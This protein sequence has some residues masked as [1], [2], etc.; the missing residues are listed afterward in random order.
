M[1]FEHN[2][3]F[4]QTVAFLGIPFAEKTADANRFK[5][6]TDSQGWKG[7]FNATYKRPPCVQRNTTG[8]KG[9]FV[10]ASN[11]TE[12]CLHLN[13]WVPT[14]CVDG[15]QRH[16]VIFWAYGGTFNTG[17][18]S[19]DF[20]D[21]RFISGFGNLVVVAPNYRVGVF[22]FLNAD[23]PDAPG[24]MALHD[25]IAAHDWVMKHIERF[26]GDRD[27][28]IL[29][30]QTPC[31]QHV[32]GAFRRSLTARARSKLTRRRSVIEGKTFV[33]EAE[34]LNLLPAVL[35]LALLDIKEFSETAFG[36]SDTARWAVL[37]ELRM[38]DSS[39][40]FLP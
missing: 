17:G 35:R 7:I 9:F 20:Y 16:P 31:P 15:N 33:L 1:S 12:D 4:F 32:H 10:D 5:K 39:A 25:M 21:G 29:A 2:G 13:V 27:N 8:P 3:V 23:A 38:H 40:Q 28:I 30:G 36:T 19:F 26:G 24:N 18:N 34:H 22:G 14:G 6:P 37:H 11:A